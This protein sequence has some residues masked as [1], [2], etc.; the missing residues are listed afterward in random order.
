MAIPADDGAAGRVEAW[1]AACQ[2]RPPPKMGTF[3]P[4]GQRCPAAAAGP[5]GLTE[6]D[7]CLSARSPRTALAGARAGLSRRRT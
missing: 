7:G 3:D 1:A 5:F 6:R 4:P 2:P